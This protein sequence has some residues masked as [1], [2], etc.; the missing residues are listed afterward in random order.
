VYHFGFS[1]ECL[2]IAHRFG[3]LASSIRHAPH[4]EALGIVLYEA[5]ESWFE[6]LDRAEPGAAFF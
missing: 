2:M 6:L 3:S 4:L 5:G 1:V